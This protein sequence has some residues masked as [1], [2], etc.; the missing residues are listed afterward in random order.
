MNKNILA[1]LAVSAV[2][3][4]AAS[5][6]VMA[7]NGA[8]V[9]DNDG[10]SMGD[11]YGNVTVYSDANHRVFNAGA[12]GLTKCYGTTPND[13]GKA[14]RFSGFQCVVW[15]GSQYLYTTRS[16]EVIDSEGNATLTCQIK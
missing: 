8:M 16:W 14:I 9:I 10:C 12:K 15:D 5:A 13:S 1:G 11:Q 3:A 7:S 6:P 2:M 4:M